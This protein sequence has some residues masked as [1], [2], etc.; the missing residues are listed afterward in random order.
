MPLSSAWMYICKFIFILS[1]AEPLLGFDCVMCFDINFNGQQF[2]FKLI[3]S[4][5]G[6]FFLL[7]VPIYTLLQK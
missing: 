2:E 3:F 4:S 7:M 1:T 6:M 5:D